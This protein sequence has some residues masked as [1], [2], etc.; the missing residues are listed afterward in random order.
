MKNIQSMFLIIACLTLLLIS[1]ASGEVN[2]KIVFTTQDFKPFSY[3]EGNEVAGPAVD[4]IRA[5]CD[6]I[7]I[8]PVF[9]LYPWPRAQAMVRGGQANGMFVIGWNEER[10]KWL[11]FSP[12]ILDTEYGFFIRVDNSL[13]L[14]DLSMLDG[15]IIGVFGPS[16][17]SRSLEKIQKQVPGIKID[18]TPDDKACFTKL[19]IGRIQAV[20][21]NKDVGFNWLGQLNYDNIRYAGAQKKLKYYIGFSKAYNDQNLVDRF[22]QAFLTL[23]KQGRIQDILNHYNMTA[24]EIEHK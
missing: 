3:L 15:Y 17:T 6:Q 10:S 20:Y 13:E 12:P 5:T 7:R 8:E 18:M 1:S 14:N 21:S 9:K 2:K 23:H 11:Y 16:N 4:I 22:N 19:S 24:S